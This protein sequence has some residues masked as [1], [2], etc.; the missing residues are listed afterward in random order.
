MIRDYWVYQNRQANAPYHQ[1]ALYVVKEYTRKTY[2]DTS[3][4]I[5]FY[6]EDIRNDIH[7]LSFVDWHFDSA[8]EYANEVCMVLSDFCE[9]YAEDRLQLENAIF[10]ILID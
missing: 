1:W 10:D 4:C 2:A 8:K 7:M 6:S 3:L 5:T 9:V